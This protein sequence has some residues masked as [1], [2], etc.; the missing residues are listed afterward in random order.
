[1]IILGNVLIS[2]P[3]AASFAAVQFFAP[4]LSLPEPPHPDLAK[5]TAAI[6]NKTGIEPDALALAAY[7]AMW[8]IARTVAAFPVPTDDFTKIKA[9]FHS[10]ANR[11]YGITGPLTWNGAGDRAPASFDYWDIV[12]DEGTYKWKW[13]GKST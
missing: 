10:E 11:F 2:D 9:V 13:V 6:K 5:I 1:M 7:D 8:V 4:N 3:T 12:D